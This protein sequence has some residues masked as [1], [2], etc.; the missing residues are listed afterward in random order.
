MGTIGLKKLA[1]IL[2]LASV[3]TVFLNLIDRHI[4]GQPA[5][6]DQHYGID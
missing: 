6:H 4:W 5:Q 2:F 1:I 3:F